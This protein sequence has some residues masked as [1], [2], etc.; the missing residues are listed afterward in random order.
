MA[1]NIVAWSVIYCRTTNCANR[2]FWGKKYVLVA[3]SLGVEFGQ[4]ILAWNNVLLTPWQMVKTVRHAIVCPAFIST[5]HSTQCTSYRLQTGSDYWLPDL[6]VSSSE[7]CDEI[8][9]WFI[10][11][12]HFMMRVSCAF[13]AFQVMKYNKTRAELCHVQQTL[14]LSLFPVIS[15][16]Y[17]VKQGMYQVRLYWF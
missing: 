13:S 11:W 12:L 9:D 15:Q 1:T 5:A 6:L 4:D 7:I 2:R 10:S 17:F 14:D 3:T 8:V 16:R